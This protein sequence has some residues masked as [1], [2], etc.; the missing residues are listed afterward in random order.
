MPIT[1]S[2]KK[3]VRQNARRRKGN[4]VYKK[5]IKSLMKEIKLLVS[6][7]KNDD[8]LKLLPQIYKALDKAAKRGVIKKNNAS[9][10]KER[11]TKLINK[12]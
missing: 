6:Q 10:N 12:K 1:T 8:A 11:I 3:A 2:A 5:N 4:I 9:R 7:K